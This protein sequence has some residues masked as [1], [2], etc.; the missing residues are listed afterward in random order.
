M[1][2]AQASDMSDVIPPTSRASSAAP[3]SKPILD[4]RLGDFESDHSAPKQRSF[5]AI[6]GSL[7]TEISLPKLVVIWTFQILAPAVLLGLAPLFLTAWIGAASSRLAEATEIGAAL[8]VIAA[9]AAAVYAWRPMFRFVELN[10]WSLNALAV[11]PGYAFWREAIR[12]LTER[13]LGGRTAHQLARTRAASCAAAGV[14]LFVVAALVAGLVWPMTQWI[15]SIADLASPLRLVLTTIANTIAVMS[16]YLAVAALVWGF[17]DAFSEQP[18]DMKAGS[19]PQSDAR[20]WRIAHLS[21]VHVVG[22]RYGFR[23]ESGRAGA[24]GNGRFERA[25]A[26][27]AAIHAG[28]PLDIVLV[29]GD[30][31]DAG[32]S[33]EWAEFLD[34]LRAFPELAART[35][36]LPGNHD[37]NIVDRANPARLDLPF[38]PIKALRRMRALSVL[39]AVQGDRVRTFS[40][41]AMVSLAQ[42]LE[43]RRSDIEAFA[44]R[45]GLRLSRRLQSLWAETFPLIL[46][47]E[48][49]TGLGVAVLDSNANTHFSFTNALGLIAAEQAKRLIV[50]LE[51]HPQAGWVIALH[52]HVT[53]YPRPVAAFSERI[54]TALING[55]WFLRQLKPYSDR[56]V[57][58]HGHRHVDWMGACGALTI[59]SA[60][61]PVMAPE[62]RDTHFHVHRVRVDPD[63]R[64]GLLAPERVEI[65]AAAVQPA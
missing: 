5:L 52:H 51:A 27:L 53:E 60:P 57:V 64:V 39:A 3:S 11:Q 26:R 31:T 16:V 43:P 40:G 46:P 41:G 25:L 2:S 49:E 32:A 55:A 17:A 44:D 6:A 47:P 37:L 18:L 50:A 29:T 21:D 54:G 62:S 30:M 34:M 61:S 28:N 20:V 1:R 35:L 23:I 22:E 45:G 38:S 24:R 15:G 7:V 4:P 14:A 36:L 12:H 48:G 42:A 19:A 10:F 8:V 63:G 33:A 58:M 56:I 13:S 65:T 9:A 59:V